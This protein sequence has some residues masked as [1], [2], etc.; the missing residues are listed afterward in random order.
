[1]AASDIRVTVHAGEPGA[2][3]PATRAAIESAYAASSFDHTGMTELGPTGVSCLQ[4]DGVH[5]IESEFIFEVLDEAGRAAPEG[6]LVAT[7]LG[8]W[9]MAVPLSDWRSRAHIAR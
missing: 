2:G 1:M 6:E 8:R 7:N 9:G 4:R 3:I 5:A